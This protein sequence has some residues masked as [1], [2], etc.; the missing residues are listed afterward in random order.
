MI[1]AI[2]TDALTKHYGPFK[3]VNG[4]NLKVPQGQVFG[5]LGP[6]GAGKTTT[7]MMLLGNVRPTSGRATLLDRPLGDIPVR[8]KIGFLPEKFQCHDFLTATEFLRLHGRLGGMSGSRLEARIGFVLERVGLETRATSKIREFSRGMQQRIGLAQAILNEPALVILDEPTSALDPVGRRDV[9]QI[10]EELRGQGKTVLLNSHILSEI[11]ATCDRVAILKQGKIIAEGTIP[12]LLTFASAVE[13]EVH[14]MND[15]ALTAVRKIV[16][17][18]KL[19]RVPITRFTAVLRSEDDIPDLAAA[20]VEN[21]VKL[22]AL[23]PKRETLEDAY[24]R[25]LESCP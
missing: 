15:A 11:E 14:S 4:L 25:L 10:V 9:R 18:L 19:E 23:I 7:I 12:E 3:A 13:V 17:K 21:G 16:Q 24:L 6:N 2:E 1:N 20:L 5:L 22:L 8:S